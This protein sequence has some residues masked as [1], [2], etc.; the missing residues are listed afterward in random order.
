MNRRVTLFVLA[1]LLGVAL[2]AA[3]LDGAVSLRRPEKIVLDNGCTVY[4]LNSP[5]LPLVSLRMYVAGAGSAYEPAGLEGLA[6]LAAELMLKG[7]ASQNA[8]AIAEELDF[9][10]ASLS[11]SAGDE[12]AQVSADSLAEHFPRVLEIASACLTGPTFPEEEF[13]RERS[14]WVDRI[15]AIKD[16]PRRAVRL[17]F[18]K[19]YFGSHP[20]GRLSSGT[21]SS[22]QK[23]TGPD[24]IRFYGEH[25]RP[26]R[27]L[28]SV[29]G[30]I[31]KDKLEALLRSTLGRWKNPL[32]AAPALDLPPLPVPKGKTLLLVDKPD[33]TQA[34]FVLGA[35]GYAVADPV[36]PT[37]SVMNTLFGGRFT[38]WLNTELRIKRGL[39]YGAGSSFQTWKQGGLFAISSYTKNDKIGEML[40]ITLGLLG[41]AQTKGFGDKE[42]ES[43]RNY[44]LGLFPLSLEQNGDKAEAY[45]RLAFYGLGFDYYDRYLSSVEK[46]TPSAAGQSA[47][48]LLPKK[49]FVMVVVGKAV[50][51]RPLLQKFG[52][53]QEK[54]ISDS[55]F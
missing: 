4:Y 16:N 33:A 34:Y 14:R 2:S 50:E 37:A 55:G 43:A 52:S 5:E 45:I 22:L 30:A 13:A 11:L 46:V 3:V 36:Y 21:E 29:V 9:M 15:A 42:V 31:D 17:Y 47:S 24:I 7:N 35:P 28:A 53:F 25:Y 40:D 26:D 18:Q 19:A 41:Q 6:G 38:S 8:E 27:C 54:K 51:I 23:I 48:K 44:I 1:V 10:G 20:L 12:F 39:T 49:D 32:T